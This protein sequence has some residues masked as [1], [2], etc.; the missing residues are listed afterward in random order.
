MEKTIRVL[1]A[2][3]SVLMRILIR[4]ILGK[5]PDM[6]V[7][8]VAGN[9]NEAYE[10]TVR[11][12]PDVVL[13][14]MNMGEYDGLYAVRKIMESR[15][16]PVVILSAM[17][18]HDMDPIMSALRMGAVDYLNKP[19]KN[20]SDLGSIG[21]EII[22][23]VRSAAGSNI[24]RE[25]PE[26]HLHA[27]HTFNSSLPYDIVVIG[28]ST[29]GPPAIEEIIYKIPQNFA[30]PIIVV[31]HMPA[32][33][34]PSFAQRLNHHCP[35]EVSMARK[36][37][38]VEPGKI[39]IAPGSRNMILRQDESGNTVIDFTSKTFK[40]YNYPS[41]NSVMISAAEL[42]GKRCIGILLTG[43]GKDGAAGMKAIHDA[44]GLTIA[45]NQQTSVVFG[46]PKEAIENGSASHVVPI[47]EIGFF[48]VSSLS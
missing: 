10:K 47:N 11:L 24:R 18:N 44:G 22:E 39:L 17:G 38:K 36:D 31:Q 41:V 15:P 25:T 2:D 46:M 6:E 45:Q 4:D 32:N 16:T 28:A 33:F 27:P 30:L 40:E 23:K 21:E 3:D 26:K 8:D 9:G 34:V 20:T 14:D 19:A 7:I 13:L 29:G 5:S 1:V 37:D 12:G 42:Y 35:L 43:M 48:L